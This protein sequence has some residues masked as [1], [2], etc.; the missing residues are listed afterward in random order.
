MIT[1]LDDPRWTDRAACLTVDPE[2][3]FPNESDAHAVRDAKVVCNRC[4]VRD[5]CGVEN[6]GEKEGIW[7]G[8]DSAE[9]KQL[10]RQRKTGAA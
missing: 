1:E 2:L 7:G 8:M 5:T 3:F 6:L 10:R 9:R 4:L